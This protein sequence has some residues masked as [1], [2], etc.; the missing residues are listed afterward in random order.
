MLSKHESWNAVDLPGYLQSEGFDRRDAKRVDKGLQ[1]FGLGEEK[2][3][4]FEQAVMKELNGVR[5]HKKQG[6]FQ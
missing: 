4:A 3:D 2:R 6:K 1:H 5:S